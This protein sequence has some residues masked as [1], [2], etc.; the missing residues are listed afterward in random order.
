MVAYKLDALNLQIP[1]ACDGKDFQMQ[2]E[3]ALIR[4]IGMEEAY[5]TMKVG[6]STFPFDFQD[7]KVTEY[8]TTQDFHPT[9]SQYFEFGQTMADQ[10][11][12]AAIENQN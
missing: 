1:G 7:Y 2:V 10:K 8:D 4:Y 6:N 3:M 11:Y 12:F 5:D 9:I